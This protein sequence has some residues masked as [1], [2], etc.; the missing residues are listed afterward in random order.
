MLSL[1]KKKNDVQDQTAVFYQR[2]F[3]RYDSQADFFIEG[4][5]GM[6]LL[7]NVSLP[8]LALESVT[9]VSLNP[10]EVHA[11]TLVPEPDSAQDPISLKAEVAWTRSSEHRFEAGFCIT[12][13]QDGDSTPVARY[14]AYL[15]SRS[16]G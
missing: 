15:K 14:V 5:E 10:K 11:I 1:F 16:E 9:Y 6:A 12:D 7:K 2:S 3:P 13:Y 4:F 8:G